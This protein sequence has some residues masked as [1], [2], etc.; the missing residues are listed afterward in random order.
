MKVYNKIVYDKDNN[1]IE[2]DSYDY[3]GPVAQARKSYQKSTKRPSK[4]YGPYTKNSGNF[5]TRFSGNKNI[6]KQDLGRVN[7]NRRPDMLGVSGPKDNSSF[8][9]EGEAYG[10]DGSVSQDKTT[11]APLQENI[12][13]NALFKYASYTTLFTLSA[14]T[15]GELENPDLFLKSAPHDIIAR[16]GGIGDPA[17]TD[18]LSS[19]N[20]G[21]IKSELG[22]QALSEARENLKGGRDL[23]FTKVE[24]MNV[25]GLNEKRRMTSVTKI[26]MVI[27]EPMGITLLDKMRG[28]AANCNY[29]DHISAPYMLSIEFKGFDELGNVVTTKDQQNMTRRIPI[30][31]ANM[32]LDVNQGSTTYTVTAIPYNEHG[33]LNHH[34]YLRTAGTVKRGKNMQETMDSLAELMNKQ[35]KDDVDQKVAEHADHY[36]IVVHKDFANET[37]FSDTKT[38]DIPVGPTSKQP[39][40]PDH[41]RAAQVK[42]NDNLLTIMTELM[43][44]LKK[45][46]DNETV[47]EFKK[48]IEAPSGDDMYFDYFMIHSSVVPDSDQF[49]R[50]RAKHPRKIKFEIKP[51]RVHAYALADPGTSTGT[52]FG[53]YVKK[54]FNYIFTGDNVDILDLDIKYRVAYF[55]SKLK[56]VEGKGSG[57]GFSKEDTESASVEKREPSTFNPFQDR[58]L[59]QSEPSSIKSV[60]AGVNKGSTTAL[61]QRLDALSNP[62]ADMVVINMTI[63]GDPSFLGQTQFIPTTAERN[64]LAENRATLASGS[65]SRMIWNK[66]FGNYNAGNGDMVV[67]L[68]FRTPTD[69]NDATGTY[70]LGKDEQIAFSGFYRVHQITNT[71]DDGKFVQRLMMTRFHNQGKQPYVPQAKKYVKFNIHNN[72]GPHIGGGLIET[73]EYVNEVSL[74]KDKFSS[75]VEGKIALLK[76]KF[77][78]GRLG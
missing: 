20:Q 77:N 43:K 16:S 53:P 1:I 18:N 33:F 48:R 69:I 12:V 21:T 67:K 66:I 73:G 42:T 62:Q 39:G 56:D 36:E 59:H 30:K 28:A 38:S 14:L 29:L 63:L 72:Y 50:I 3:D 54:E 31:I 44:G 46:T 47:E 68:N 74:V 22:Q 26:D 7:D 17:P 41:L 70:E 5:K 19:E 4:N 27:T 34:V 52:Y 78:I 6:N 58:F 75:Y 13:P 35:A 2:E 61:D 24:M 40:K 65:N 23:Y 60:S 32:Q 37:V 71:F 8:D 76:A 9:Y 11:Q 64:T 57:D 55:Q 15:Q 49:D 10:Y 45:F 25:P 51:Y